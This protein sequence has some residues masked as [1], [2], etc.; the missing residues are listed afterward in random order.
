M[1]MEQCLDFLKQDNCLNVMVEVDLD[2]IINSV[3]KIHHGIALDKV[4]KHW[5]LIRFFQRIQIHL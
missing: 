4:S 5:K 1:A 3:Q 2:L